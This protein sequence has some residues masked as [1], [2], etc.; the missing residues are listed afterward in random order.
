MQE[1]GRMGTSVLVCSCRRPIFE[2][3]SPSS[4]PMQG[5]HAHVHGIGGRLSQGV[6]RPKFAHV[7]HVHSCLSPTF[8][9][10]TAA[11]LQREAAARYIERQSAQLQREAGL[12]MASENDALRL[13]V[14]RQMLANALEVE[15]TIKCAAAPKAGPCHPFPTC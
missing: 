10:R 3:V 15:R 6:V 1:H 9:Y 4:E 5:R 7:A 8:A 12:R 13:A 11:D 14:E 2:N